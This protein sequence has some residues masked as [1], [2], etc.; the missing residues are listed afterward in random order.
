MAELSDQIVQT[1]LTAPYPCPAC[2]ERLLVI[3][4]INDGFPEIKAEFR[5]VGCKADLPVTVTV[6]DRK[7]RFRWGDEA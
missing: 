6:L 7:A 4:S 1:L 5:C 3:E 2:K